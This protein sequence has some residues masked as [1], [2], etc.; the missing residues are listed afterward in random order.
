MMKNK[1]KST[2]SPVFA[3]GGGNKMVGQ[4]HA[5]TQKPGQT[6]TQATSNPK[7]AEGGSGRMVG[8]Q[9]ANPAKKA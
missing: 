9:A 4:Q 8:K 2:S 7:F 3:K 1:Q 5:G 6:G